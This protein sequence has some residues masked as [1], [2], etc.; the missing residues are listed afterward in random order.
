MN[1]DYEASKE[2]LNYYKQSF[3]TILFDK[4]FISIFNLDNIKDFILEVS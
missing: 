2:D 4:D 3:E 1:K